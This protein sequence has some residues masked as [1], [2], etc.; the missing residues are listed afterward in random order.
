MGGFSYATN[1]DWVIASA[2]GG[3]TN[4][5]AAGFTVDD[6]LSRMIWQADI[7]VVRTNGDSL[8]L[9]FTNNHPPSAGTYT[10]YSTGN[11]TAIPIVNLLP[12]WK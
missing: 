5:N 8:V 9:S 10:T 7:F 3:I 2:A 1:F 6:L 12:Y 11:V 4:F